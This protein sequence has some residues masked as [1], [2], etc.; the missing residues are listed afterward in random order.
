MVG[1]RR[2]E[3]RSSRRVLQDLHYAVRTLLR[4]PGFTLTAAL[5]LALGIGA[6]TVMF[7]V[8]NAVLLRPLPYREPGRLMLLFSVNSR[9][10]IGQIRATALDFLDWRRQAQSFESMAAHVGTGFTF[11][12]AGDPE[13]VL[14]QLVTADFFNVLRVAP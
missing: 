4:S 3:C 12:G 13:F 9:K 7:S 1:T 14:G 8:V 11:S 6:N 5:T 2:H 10:D